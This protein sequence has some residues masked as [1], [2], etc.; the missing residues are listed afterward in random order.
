MPGA[1]SEDTPIWRY[2][3]LPRFLAM[4]SRGTTGH[5]W[6]GRLAEYEDKFEG[7]S[8]AVAREAPW[9]DENKPIEFEGP[10]GKQWVSAAGMLSQMSHYAA[11]AYED[12]R[13]RLYVN[14]WCLA[15]ESV[16]MWE[17]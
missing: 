12:A 4:I 11:R 17:I 9:D 5:L 7:F 8:Q 3:D 15:N 13:M 16:A 2:M 10:E 1:I 14:S 6:F